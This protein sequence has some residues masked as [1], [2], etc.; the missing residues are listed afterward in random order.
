MSAT[1]IT[2]DRL[3]LRLTP[4]AQLAV[5]TGTQDKAELRSWFAQLRCRIKLDG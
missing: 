4:L 2:R 1:E 5:E 3:S